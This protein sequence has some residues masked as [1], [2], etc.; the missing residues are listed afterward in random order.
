M[1]TLESL[2]TN[3]VEKKDLY[4]S[5]TELP[6]V[7]GNQESHEKHLRE[8]QKEIRGLENRIRQIEGHL[9]ATKLSRFKE[10]MDPALIRVER[11]S[12]AKFLGA[13]EKAT[14]AGEVKR[15]LDKLSD[16]TDPVAF[17]QL[18]VKHISDMVEKDP[19]RMSYPMVKRVTAN[20]DY[21]AF[22]IDIG[23]DKMT[24][25]ELEAFIKSLG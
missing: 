24:D 13:L 19:T 8:I 17:Y 22:A 3:L 4:N 1:V 9:S 16:Q 18:V 23:F 2:K 6:P 20:T 14:S 12:V 11:E 7:P 10:S 25:S 5:L 21:H 15:I